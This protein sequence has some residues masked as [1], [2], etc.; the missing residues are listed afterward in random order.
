VTSVSHDTSNWITQIAD[1]R[2]DDL[3]FSFDSR[4]CLTARNASFSI[5]VQYFESI[6]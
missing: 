5:G 6:P 3:N 4:Q 2:G 1:A